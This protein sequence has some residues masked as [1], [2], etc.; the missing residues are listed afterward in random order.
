[1]SQKIIYIDCKTTGIAG[2]MLLGALLDLQDPRV[3]VET[4]TAGL[5]SV[6]STKEWSIT[7]KTVRK[8]K[9]QI[10]ATKADVIIKQELSNQQTT[11]SHGHGHGHG[12]SHTIE[13]HGHGHGQRIK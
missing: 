12:H 10:A 13:S 2:D 9:G 5:A 6:I 7:S 1:M 11:P 4:L 8:G 3:T